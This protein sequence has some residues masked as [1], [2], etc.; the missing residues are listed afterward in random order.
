MLSIGVCSTQ[1]QLV[2]V[3]HTI[4]TNRLSLTYT[5]LT[6]IYIPAPCLGFL[7][8]AATTISMCCHYHS[9]DSG[10]VIPGTRRQASVPP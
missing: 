4:C 5:N 8:H 3:D 2:Q 7:T 10:I 9:S 1:T 6:T